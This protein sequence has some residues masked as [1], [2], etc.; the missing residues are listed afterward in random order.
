MQR[1]DKRVLD[2]RAYKR[3]VRCHL[4]KRRRCDGTSHGC[5]KV[6]RRNSGELEGGRRTYPRG[7]EI[8]KYEKSGLGK[9]TV[10]FFCG[11]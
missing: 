7:N 9:W 4:E 2:K 8:F 6:K 10:T 11:N 5:T 3:I 1:V